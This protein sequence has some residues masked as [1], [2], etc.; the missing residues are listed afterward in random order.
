MYLSFW[1][2]RITKV[3]CS[4]NNVR[5]LKQTGRVKRRGWKEDSRR[6]REEKVAKKVVEKMLGK[7]RI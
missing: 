1:A 5:V 7:L 4:I 2:V 3:K 6:C